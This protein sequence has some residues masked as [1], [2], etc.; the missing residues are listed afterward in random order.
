MWFSSKLTRHAPSKLKSKLLDVIG[1]DCAF[2]SSYIHNQI[3]IIRQSG[4]LSSTERSTYVAD[5]DVVHQA[6]HLHMFHEAR[7]PR[8]LLDF[9]L[10]IVLQN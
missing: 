9:F 5:E 1:M 10:S 3:D 4:K 2:L 6:L 7:R 8:R